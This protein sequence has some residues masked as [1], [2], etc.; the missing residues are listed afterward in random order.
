MIATVEGNWG[1]IGLLAG[2]AREPRQDF[3]AGAIRWYDYLVGTIGFQPHAPGK[4]INYFDKPRGKIPNNSVEAAWFFLRLWQATGQ[5]RFLEHVGPMLDFL[6]AVQLPSGELPYIV[7]GPYERE[8]IHYLCFQY[9]AFQFLKLAWSDALL[10]DP[11]TRKILSSLARFL[12]KGVTATG[13]SAVDCF[14][15]SAGNRLLYGRARRRSRRSGQ[16]EADRNHRP[17]RAVLCSNSGAAAAGR[18]LR[19]H[20]WRLWFPPGRTLVPATAGHDFVSFALSALGKGFRGAQASR[21]CSTGIYPVAQPSTLSTGIAPE[22]RRLYCW[23]PP[24]VGTGLLTDAY[25]RHLRNLQFRN[26]RAR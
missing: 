13:A 5:A 20:N 14:A 21:R 19:L 11:R 22:A 17:Q 7:E 23:G 1:A 4:A 6:A 3:L 10:P 16:A 26:A 25:V 24:A 2:Y 12:S 18:K 9:N 15:P 8:R